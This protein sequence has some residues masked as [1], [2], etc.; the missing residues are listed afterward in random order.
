VEAHLLA[1]ETTTEKGF[2]RYV[3]S[4]TSPLRTIPLADLRTDAPA[5]VRALFP[6]QKEL[7][8]E[9]SGQMLPGIDRVYVNRRAREE[10]GW[11]ARYDFRHLLD[12]LREGRDAFSPLAR[13]SE[14]RGIT[15]S[16][17]RTARTR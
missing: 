2:R 15:R 11:L 6:D 13:G 14:A 12:R 7:Y 1:D 10:L 5:V 4:A 16:T 9:R 8:H 3:P 17:S